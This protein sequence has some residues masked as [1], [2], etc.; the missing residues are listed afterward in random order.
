VALKGHGFSRAAR[1][2]KIDGASALGGC[3]L[4]PSKAIPQ[5]LKP[6]SF[7]SACFGTTEAVP[8]QDKMLPHLEVLLL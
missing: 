8:F 6:E 4:L 2:G 7:S 3:I 1:V 5:G